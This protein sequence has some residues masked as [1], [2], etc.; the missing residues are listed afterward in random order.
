M[1]QCPKC[2]RNYT[3]DSL[4]FCLDDGTV[5]NSVSAT[6]ENLV[7]P[8]ESATE[9]LSGD[10]ITK[11]VS[12]EP[13]TENLSHEQQT[14]VNSPNTSSNYTQTENIRHGVSPIF[15]YLTI[16]LLAILIL[17]A[18]VG[19]VVWMNSNSVANNEISN[20]VVK[21]NIN[22]NNNLSID[23]NAE[24]S[25]DNI[26][27]E[28]DINKNS[29]KLENPTP[30]PTE[31]KKEDIKPTP[32]PTET[33]K[34]TPTQTTKPTP[35]TTPTPESQ[36]K[37]F[38]VLGSYPRSQAAKARQ[39]LQFARSK[40]VNAKIINTSN[41][42]GLRKGLIAIVIG[43]YSKSEAQNALSRV[44]GSIPDAYIKAAS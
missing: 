2:N 19:L 29:I 4:N 40:G 39:R 21:N 18:G 14:L 10:Q 5:L 41:Y 12:A 33:A 16:G 22:S 6:D 35:T 13:I 20:E 25:K 38:V 28:N 30:K 32:K 37:Y 27:S 9:I 1:K 26:N 24:E 11:T 42:G 44:R 31:I 3:D 8:T 15:A 23:K 7:R 43:P 17:V 36:G 34:P